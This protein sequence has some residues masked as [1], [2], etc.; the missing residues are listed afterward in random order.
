LL[1]LVGKDLIRLLLG[2]KWEAA[3]QIF[4][5][6]GPGIGIM[7][8][9]TTSG[10]IH[11]SIGRPDRWF[12]WVLFEFGITVLLFL[13]GLHWGPAGVAAAWTTSFWILTIPAFWYAGRPI[14]FGVG[15]IVSIVWKY[16]VAS[17]LAGCASALI[18]GQIA[19]LIAATGASGAAIRILINTSLLLVL[20]VGA[21]VL[22]HG[23]T[24]PLDRLLRLVPDM[25]PGKRQSRAD[26][27]RETLQP[28]RAEGAPSDDAPQEKAG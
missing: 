21:V 25:L 24:E 14:D 5:L 3:G 22:L 7:L 6:F 12:R 19:S 9:Y 13:I 18:F 26:P 2:T 23:G 17:L 20:Y 16:V 15:P 8:I 28:D 27:A 11:L 4:T 1:T 10:V